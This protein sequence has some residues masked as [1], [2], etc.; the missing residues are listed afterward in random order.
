MLIP[1]ENVGRFGVNFDRAA[2]AQVEA[3]V[4]AGT[5]TAPTYEELVAELPQMVW[6]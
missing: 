4:R 3:A 2:A 1:I 5:R 6:P